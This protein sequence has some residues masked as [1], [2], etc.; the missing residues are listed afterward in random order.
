MRWVFAPGSGV[1][2]AA[3]ILG[4]VICVASTAETLADVFAMPSGQTSLTLLPVGNVGNSS[5]AATGFGSVGYSYNISKFETTI[6]QYV[7]FLNAVGATD[8]YSL[9]NASMTSRDNIAGIARNGS[10]GNY[11]YSAIGS[12]N[13]PVA[14][15]GWGDA[16]RFAN[17]MT[18]GQPTGAQTAGTTETGSYL[19][20][21]AL[22]GAELAAVVRSAGARYVIPT[23]NEWYK[24]AYYDPNKGGSGY[25]LYPMRTDLKPNSAPPP[26]D[27]CA[28]AAHAGNFFQDDFI[29]NTYDNGYA[30]TGAP[31]TA[32]QNY[33]TDVG[34]Y[35]LA[36]TYYGTCDQDGNL[37]EWDETTVS[38]ALRGLR[39]SAW[40]SSEGAMR[41]T[42]RTGG[43][44]ATEDVAYGFRV[45][46]VPEPAGMMIW[47][48]GAMGLIRR[49]RGPH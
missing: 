17:W 46:E 25:W 6:G 15:V 41:A 1:K 32:S 47:L 27:L 11:T 24:A 14:Y 18:N 4:L 33:L 28:S 34:A 23:E 39:G 22:S 20:N 36:S 26:G 30:V 35:G 19:L 48:M 13:K 9:Y 16:A 37:T 8:T 44:P 38:G 21:G 2:R 7:Q 49:G 42:N 31:Y 29:A 45:A 3:L 43:S 10:S 5:D 12:P 40:V